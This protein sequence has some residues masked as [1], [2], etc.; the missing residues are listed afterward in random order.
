MPAKCIFIVE[1][2]G[3]VAAD[4]K[5]RLTRMGYVVAGWAAAGEKAIEQ[6]AKIKPDLVL[7]DIILQGKM[8]GVEVAEHVLKDHEIPCIF[9]TAHA[10]DP[11]MKRASLTGPFGYVLKPCD[12]RELQVAVEIALSRAGIESELR[13]ANRD[14][15]RALAQIKTLRGLLPICA[16]CEKIR[17]E[18]DRWQEFEN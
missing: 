13:Q 7:I 8:D 16:W 11:T 6:V 5:E 12:E 10:D 17:D 2:E 3:I 15:A 18:E 14:L 1:D 4:L 9:L